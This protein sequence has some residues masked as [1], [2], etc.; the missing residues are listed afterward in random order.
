[1]KAKLSKEDI[2]FILECMKW[3]RYNFSQKKEEDCFNKQETINEIETKL[4]L[5][6]NE[7]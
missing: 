2:E 5:I 3:N 1:M 6:K 4:K 7:N